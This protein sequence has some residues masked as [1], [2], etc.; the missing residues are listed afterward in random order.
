MHKC[1]LREVAVKAAH[2]AFGEFDLATGGGKQAVVARL[3]HIESRVKFGAT[4]ANQDIT[5]ARPLAFVEFNAETLTFRVASQPCSGTGFLM[6]HRP[7]ESL[8][9]E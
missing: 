6:C 3:H 7:F 5:R 1:S 2:L 4:L 9:I 8:I